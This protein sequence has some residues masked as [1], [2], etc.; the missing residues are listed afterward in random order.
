MDFNKES[1][2]DIISV[3]NNYKNYSQ[4]ETMANVGKNSR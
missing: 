1:T 4:I 2:Q 3:H